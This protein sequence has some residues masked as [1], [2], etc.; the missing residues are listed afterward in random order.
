VRSFE[1]ADRIIAEGLADYISMSR[2]LIREP[3]LI[4]RWQ[5]GDRRKAECRS[6]N[7]CFNPGFEGKG[8]YCVTQELENNNAPQ[9]AAGRFS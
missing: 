9:Q 4:K 7:L 6:D 1:V 8:V 2:P 3:H 5:D